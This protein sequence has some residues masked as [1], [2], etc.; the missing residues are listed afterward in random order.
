MLRLPH[1]APGA[2][3]RRRHRP[4]RRGDRLHGAQPALPGV[5]Q[6]AL[7][8]GED[9]G[10]AAGPL[11]LQVQS[12]SVRTGSMF[13]KGKKEG[14]TSQGFTASSPG[15]CSKFAAFLL[16]FF[17]LFVTSYYQFESAK[18]YHSIAIV[19]HH[20]C[21]TFTKITSELLTSYSEMPKLLL[22]MFLSSL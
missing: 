20:F 17:R 1:E 11:K 2:R 18:L 4:L 14:A 10:P 6:H 7:Q 3:Q 15:C 8:R 22:S 9:A 16:E 5:H 21:V 12:Q 13:C 19:C